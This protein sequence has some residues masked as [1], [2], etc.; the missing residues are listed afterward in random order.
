MKRTCGD[1]FTN[2]KAGKVTAKVALPQIRKMWRQESP[3][4]FIAE[5]ASRD[6]ASPTYVA[7]PTK[8]SA[9][10]ILWYGTQAA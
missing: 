6:K 1:C 9:R 3:A 2:T 10:P 7:E 5:M 4:A 8:A